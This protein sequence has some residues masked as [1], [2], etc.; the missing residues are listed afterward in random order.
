MQFFSVPY[1]IQRILTLL[2]GRRLWEASSVKKYNIEALPTGYL[3]IG[4]HTTAWFVGQVRSIP[5]DKRGIAVMYALGAQ[6][7]GMRFLYLEAGLGAAH[8]IPS[9][10]IAQVRKQFAGVL[11]VGGGVSTPEKLRKSLRQVQ[12]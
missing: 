8:S 10:M 2:L 4:E 1:L 7:L 12:I 5:F 11:I 6:Y 9:D 3:V